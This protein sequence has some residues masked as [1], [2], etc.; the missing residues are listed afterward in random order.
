MRDALRLLTD[1]DKGGVLNP[2]DMISIGDITMTVLD[3]LKNKHPQGMPASRD[4]LIPPTI[5]QVE[6][7]P[8]IFEK[9]YASLIR[10]T[11]LRTSGSAG[12][13]GTDAK[14]WRTMCTSFNK[15]SDD[16]CH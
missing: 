7:H 3:A 10:A 15:E 8:V 14:M 16:L 11:A 6:V 4:A 12:P 13:S 2:S 9:I 1:E 5:N